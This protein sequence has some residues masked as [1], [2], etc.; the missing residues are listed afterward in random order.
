LIKLGKG[1]DATNMTRPKLKSEDTHW[2]YARIFGSSYEEGDAMVLKIFG[3]AQKNLEEKKLIERS[4]Y[5]RYGEGGPHL[6]VRFLT[7]YFQEVQT[8]IEEAATHYF[9]C[10]A[11]EQRLQVKEPPAYKALSDFDSIAWNLL[12][13]PGTLEYAEYEPEYNKYGGSA[14]LPYCEKLFD[15]SSKLALQAL[16]QEQTWQIPRQRL[17]LYMM[18]KLVE[19]FRIPEQERARW[20]ADYFQY[21]SKASK[22]SSQAL[23]SFATKYQANAAFINSLVREPEKIT[24]AWLNQMQSSIEEW[25]IVAAKQ[26]SALLELSEESKLEGQHPSTIAFHVMHVHNNRAGVSM[27]HEAYLSYLLWRYYETSEK[28]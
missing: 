20:F 6:R 2:V 19:V 22:F 24:S 15:A 10:A 13:E 18:N 8:V 11:G 1:A 4:F 7:K 27:A 9:T 17:A 3:T 21:W 25:R 28:L 23:D 14:G 5:L 12:R 26:Y 16:E